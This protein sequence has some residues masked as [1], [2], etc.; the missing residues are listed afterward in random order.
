MG[1]TDSLDRVVALSGEGVMYVYP[2]VWCMCVCVRVRTYTERGSPSTCCRS[3]VP[4]L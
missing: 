4:L 1:R 2:D 3:P